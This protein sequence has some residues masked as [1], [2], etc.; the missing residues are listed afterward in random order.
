MKKFFEK[1]EELS[2]AG[3]TKKDIVFL[4]LSAIALVLSLGKRSPN[5]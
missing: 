5:P 2:E 1:L 3:G 4:V